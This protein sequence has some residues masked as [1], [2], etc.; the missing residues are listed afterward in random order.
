MLTQ[1]LE[2]SIN[3][4]MDKKID[5]HN[6]HEEWLRQPG[7]CGDYNKLLAQAE[8]DRDKAKERLEVCKANLTEVKARLELNIRK[9]PE[10]YDPPTKKSGEI[11]ATEG[12][13]S[14]TILI[15]MKIDDACSKAIQ[16]L[17]DAQNALIEA[18]YKVNLYGAGVKAIQDRKAAL[19]H[20]VYLWSRGY[21]SV[22]DLPRPLIEDYQNARLT[23]QD[24][25]VGILRQII[26]KPK[27]SDDKISDSKDATAEEKERAVA[28]PRRRRM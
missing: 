13:V 23:S 14:S 16:E 22:P 27:D 28:S 9:E 24:E 21:F 20:E 17:A 15:N 1:I 18:N 8:N 11:N 4:E 3:Y 19:E 7:L 5:V 10:K 26:Q 6:L 2:N 12:W 25:A